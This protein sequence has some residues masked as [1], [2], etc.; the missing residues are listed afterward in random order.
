M[1]TR[2]QCARNSRCRRRRGNEEDRR[3][4]E[5]YGDFLV[6]HGNHNDSTIYRASNGER[7][8]AFFGRVI[9]GATG[10]LGLSAATW[11]ATRT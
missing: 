7:V 3:W 10:K 11:T 6:V 5:E 4:A 8:G 2:A 9:A 1:G